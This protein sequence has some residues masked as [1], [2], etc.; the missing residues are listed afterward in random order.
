MCAIVGV[1]SGIA[2]DSIALTGLAFRDHISSN[3]VAELMSDTLT[4]WEQ[5]GRQLN[6][7]EFWGD[8]CD[9]PFE[10]MRR[11]YSSQ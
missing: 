9:L 1:K 5:E 8:M 4:W 10:N 7:T 11:F 2:P 6:L 3:E